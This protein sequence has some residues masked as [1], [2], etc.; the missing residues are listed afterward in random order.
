MKL[1]VIKQDGHYIIPVLERAGLDLQSFYVE[2][3]QDIEI[4][5]SQM[6]VSNTINQLQE[7]NKTLG[8]DEYLTFKLKNLPKHYS[9]KTTQSDEEILAEALIEKYA[10]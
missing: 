3:D 8:G 9:Y 7:L 6:T 4:K 5:L 10:K 1:Q 2:V